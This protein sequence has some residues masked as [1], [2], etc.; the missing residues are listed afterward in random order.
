MCHSVRC[1]FCQDTHHAQLV[2]QSLNRIKS[3]RIAIDSDPNVE[4]ST[5][6]CLLENKWWGPVDKDQN[7]AVRTMSQMTCSMISVNKTCCQHPFPMR[8]RHVVWNCLCCARV[9]FLPITLLEHQTCKKINYIAWD[10]QRNETSVPSVLLWD[11][12]RS[13]PTDWPQQHCQSV[14]LDTPAQNSHQTSEVTHSILVASN[15]GLYLEANG[16][17]T[18]L[19]N[20]L[21]TFVSSRSTSST[22]R[23]T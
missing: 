22:A 20:C 7:T 21:P 12:P 15:W 11:M 10:K 3:H 19:F 18:F 17:T 8:F 5:V 13:E 1:L 16:N 2:L 9:I 4:D 14:P 23:C 6:A